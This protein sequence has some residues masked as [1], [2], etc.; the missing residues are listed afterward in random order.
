[1]ITA[2]VDV[3]VDADLPA[4][5]VD[6]KPVWSSNA[7]H[8]A[9]ENAAYH[10]QRDGQAFGVKSP[11]DFSRMAYA[12][13]ASPPK[14]AQILTRSNGD[15]LIYDPVGNVFAVATKDGEP[16]TIF[17]PDDGPAYWAKQKAEVAK[18]A[19]RGST[20]EEG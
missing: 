14:D 7:T 12:F 19:E 15:K 20:R 11:E 9:Q 18:Q 10:F 4:P 6:G 13:V 8:S 2:P 17:K 5:T 3:R 1:V 16:R